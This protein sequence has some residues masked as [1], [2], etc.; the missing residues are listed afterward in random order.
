[1]AGACIA[2]AVA[3]HLATTLLVEASVLKAFIRGRDELPRNAASVRITLCRRGRS[4][5]PRGKHD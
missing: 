2:G 1:M 4:D 5:V 3:R